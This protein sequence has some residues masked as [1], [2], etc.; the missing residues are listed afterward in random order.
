MSDDVVWDKAKGE[1]RILGQRHIAIDIQGL[2]E[3]LDLIVGPM[4]AEVVMNQHEFRQ[5]KEDAA[6][7]RQEKPEATIQE[8]VNSFANAE[9]LSGVGVVR[10]IIT[11]ASPG[12]IDVEISNPCVKK[13]TGAARS[14]LFSYWCGVFTELLGNEFK[15][16]QVKYDE[17]KNLLKGRVIPR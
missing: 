5:G 14:F 15:I 2:C 8:L 16:D 9:T 10:V 6:S 11:E 13:T 4:V 12:P 3:H 7:A 17:N 1:L